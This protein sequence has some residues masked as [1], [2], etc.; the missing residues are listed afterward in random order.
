M[1]VLE[2]VRPY[3]GD[4]AFYKHVVAIALPISM[5]SL[6]TIGVNMTDTIMLGKLG[7]TAL[8]ASSLANQFISIF[9]ICCMGIG[10]GASVLTSRFW[11]MQDKHSLRKAITIMLR[12]C[13]VFG[14]AFTVATILAPEGLMRIYTSD[15]A[16]IQAGASYFRWSLPCY[17]LLRFSL[18]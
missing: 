11:G 8:S 18:T 14:L 3:L 7:E 17:W 9:Q 6:I 13:F 5:Q 2:R 12:L 1:G 4:K 10:M 15:P 16:I